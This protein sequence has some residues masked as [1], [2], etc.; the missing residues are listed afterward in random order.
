[1]IKLFLI[2]PLL[3]SYPNIDYVKVENIEYYHTNKN[4]KQ[5]I[6]QF[7]SDRCSI[8]TIKVYIHL[9]SENDLLKT[10]YNTLT[11][12]SK[13][14]AVA[15]IDVLEAKN[16]YVLI[17]VE[18]KE[19]DLIDK[20]KI[21]FHTQNNCELANKNSKC[22]LIYKTI[23]KEGELKEEKLIFNVDEEF[24]NMYLPLNKLDEKKLKVHTNYNFEKASAYLILH[25]QL[26]KYDLP[27]TN[28]YYFPIE[29][30]QDSFKISDTYYLNIE[31]FKFSTKYTYNSFAVNSLYFPFSR[32]YDEYSLEILIEGNIDI[33]IKFKVYTK[34][35]LFGKCNESKYCL[36]KE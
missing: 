28:G 19:N 29:Y 25:N 4:N 3:F 20:V 12:S 36:V 21:N 18:Y 34:G 6:F 16:S 14:K 5:I 30:S 11:F 31:Q 22:N 35:I 15:N 23:Y 13:K 9:Y 10:Y 26:D 1:M 2:L 33:S 8:H 32:D 17:R 7:D 27:F 24:Y